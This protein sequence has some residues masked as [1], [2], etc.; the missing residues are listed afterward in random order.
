MSGNV[1]IL[2][3][4][5]K[6]N[7]EISLNEIKLQIKFNMKMEEINGTKYTQVDKLTFDFTP[8][9]MKIK[10]GNLYNGDKLLGDATNAFLNENWQSIFMDLKP[11]FTK[12]FGAIAKRLIN[13]V[14]RKIS[15][16]SAFL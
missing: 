9:S 12:A 4:Q 1:L 15:Y 14:F 5:G 2:P 7:S 11:E 10:L 6:G 13:N 3:V 8:S 16:E